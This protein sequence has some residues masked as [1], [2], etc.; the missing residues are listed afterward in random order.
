MLVSL[1]R[2]KFVVIIRGGRKCNLHSPDVAASWNLDMEKIV[3]ISL[4]VYESIPIGPSLQLNWRGNIKYEKYLNNLHG[5]VIRSVVSSNR[6]IYL[7]IPIYVS[8]SLI[9]I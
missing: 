3:L 6:N 2:S 1:P 7:G 9:N 8:I 5:H 4:L